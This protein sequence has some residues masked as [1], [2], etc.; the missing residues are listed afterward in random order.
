MKQL[1]ITISISIFMGVV[2]LDCATNK[3]IEPESA[4]FNIIFSSPADKGNF[5]TSFEKDTL[6]WRLNKA[7]ACIGEIGIHWDWRHTTAKLAKATHDIPGGKISPKIYDYFAIDFLK[8]QKL[9]TLQVEPKFYDHIHMIFCRA[10][11]ETT[12]IE[13]AGRL[14]GYSI[15]FEGKVTHGG[16]ET[17][18]KVY[19]DSTY[20]ENDLG[21]VTF[22]FQALKDGAY[23]LVLK[24][25]ISN[26]FN[27]IIWSDLSPTNGDT[28]VIN[29]TNKNNKAALKIENRFT[30]DNSFEF[31]V[32]TSN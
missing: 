8:S 2:F 17:P 18:F 31:S 12:G 22:E 19:F 27:D 6:F 4:E 9:Q 13:E 26:W 28:V 5:F 11:S 20:N 24:P 10:D 7:Y 25:K 23:D 16:K 30:L 29:K 1:L 15:Y 21:D 14:A 3:I 32:T